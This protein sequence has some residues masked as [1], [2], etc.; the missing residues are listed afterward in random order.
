MSAADEIAAILAAVRDE[1]DGVEVA[2]ADGVGTWS[3][4]GR[5]FARQTAGGVEIRLDPA[6]GAAALRTADTSRSDAGPDWISF[7]PAVVDR[8]AE[9][10]LRAWLVHA[11]RVAAAERAGGGRPD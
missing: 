9:D 10:R 4:G 5:A 1:L 11:R 2:E 7:R 3:V 8:F 6:V